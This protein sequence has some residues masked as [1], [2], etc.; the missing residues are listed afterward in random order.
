MS[1][2]RAKFAVNW[3]KAKWH[4]L[5][6]SLTQNVSVTSDELGQFSGSVRKSLETLNWS[7][8]S[9]HNQTTDLF[10]QGIMHFAYWSVD[11]EGPLVSLLAIEVSRSLNF[12]VNN[13][14][15]WHLYPGLSHFIGRIRSCMLA[16]CCKSNVSDLWIKSVNGHRVLKREFRLFFSW[17]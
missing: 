12:V 7:Q 17:I 5:A 8:N 14:D 4:T 2:I 10:I 13:F 3:S 1:S 9:D 16:A 15:W 11:R 6:W